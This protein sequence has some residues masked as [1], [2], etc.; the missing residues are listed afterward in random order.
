MNETCL[1]HIF[2]VKDRSSKFVNVSQVN[3]VSEAKIYL[4]NTSGSTLLTIS[5]YELTDSDYDLVFYTNNP[6][7]I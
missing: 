2:S 7:T 3:W 1:K 4:E 5:S 6:M